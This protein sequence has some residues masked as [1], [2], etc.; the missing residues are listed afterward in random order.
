MQVPLLD[1]PNFAPQ[2]KNKRPV[3]V[4]RF[5]RRFDVPDR[6][7][8]S[9]CLLTL[10]LHAYREQTDGA[11]CLAKLQA[12]ANK[13]RKAT[14][15]SANNNN[16][17]NN[18]C[19]KANQGKA[20][21]R[22]SSAPSRRQ[23]P[24]SNPELRHFLAQ[25][26]AELR[27]NKCNLGTEVVNQDIIKNVAKGKKKKPQEAQECG[28]PDEEEHVAVAQQC[29][30]ETAEQPA[31]EPQASAVPPA[32]SSEEACKPHCALE[33]IAQMQTA[34]D[35][36][37][38]VQLEYPPQFIAELCEVIEQTKGVKL[39]KPQLTAALPGYESDVWA[40]SFDQLYRCLL[41]NYVLCAQSNEAPAK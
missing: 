10:G 15:V 39:T 19:I 3:D 31:P 2:V 7:E 28:E 34:D 26:R 27:R 14:L 29:Q 38:V 21:N 23:P 6:L 11:A 17:N 30:N 20:I 8:V 37:A 18:N 4:A 22:S 9:N 35:R 32:T 24:S 33:W 13:A 41:V 5:L 40:A 16:N 25:Q 1:T 12:V 36:R